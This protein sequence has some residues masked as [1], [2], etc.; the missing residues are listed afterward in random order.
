MTLLADLRAR[1][2]VRTL[3]SDLGSNPKVAKNDKLNVS[4]A[5]LHLAPGNMSGREVCPKRSAGCTAACLHFAGSPAYMTTKTQAR[6]KR[7]RLFFDDRNLFMNILALEIAAH[8]IRAERKGMKPAI[9]LNGTSDIVWEKKKFILFPEVKAYLARKFP[10]SDREQ[11]V[12][13]RIFPTLQFYDY[14]AIPGRESLGNYHLTFSLKEDNMKEV[15]AEMKRGRNIAVVFPAAEIPS[16]Y[17]GLPVVDGDET[18]YR[19]A[20]PSPCV[21]GLKVKGLKGKA[22]TSGFVQKSHSDLLAA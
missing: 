11:N 3:L 16:E 10:V 7:T 20:D 22:D 15:I 9:R 13:D 6:L 12:I 4:T 19:P 2:G 1:A 18:D 21:V 14:T 5:V 8:A 17:L